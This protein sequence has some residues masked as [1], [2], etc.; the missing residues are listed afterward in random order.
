MRDGIRSAHVNVR[1]TP[2]ERTAIAARS[3]R[4]GMTPSAYVRESALLRDEAPVR[5]ADE[6]ELRAIHVGLKRIGN[7]L[8]QAVRALNARGPEPAT[9]KLLEHAVRE[10]SKAAEGISKLLSGASERR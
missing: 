5:V 7:N 3:A 6:G 9:M 10:V 1:V 8:N 4:C 2:K